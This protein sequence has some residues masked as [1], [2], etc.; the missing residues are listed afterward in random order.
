[1]TAT[2]TKAIFNTTWKGESDAFHPFTVDG[3]RPYERRRGRRDGDRQC[4]ETSVRSAAGAWRRV[5]P[6][7]KFRFGSFVTQETRCR[8]PGGG[9]FAA[10]KMV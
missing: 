9:F 10:N 1:M 2:K 8:I 4:R 6:A 7:R 5:R 3:P